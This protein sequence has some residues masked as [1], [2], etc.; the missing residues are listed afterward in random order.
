M[1]IYSVFY[2]FLLKPVNSKT[3]VQEISLEINLSSQDVEF[4][5]EKI[6]DEQKISDQQHFLIK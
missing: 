6:L 2:V 1:K 5:V 3:S 4:K